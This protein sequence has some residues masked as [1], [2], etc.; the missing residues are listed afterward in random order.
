VGSSP[1]RS[2][3]TKSPTAPRRTGPSRSPSCRCKGPRSPDGR[4]SPA[5]SCRPPRVDRHLLGLAQVD[6]VEEVGRD[7]EERR[8]RVR[9]VYRAAPGVVLAAPA[10][11]REQPAAAQT[12]LRDRFIVMR[13]EQGDTWS[14]NPRGA[15]KLRAAA[16][17]FSPF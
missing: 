4:S 6:G 14:R 15:Q 13:S 12:I 1:R 5:R 11:R 9:I 8:R 10:D 7:V 2:A 17:P 16:V 3:C